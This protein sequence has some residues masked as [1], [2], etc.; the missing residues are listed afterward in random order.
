MPRPFSCW[1]ILSLCLLAHAGLATAQQPPSEAPPKLE[2]IEPGSD[3]PAT[4]VPD[5]GRTK[6]IEKKQGGQVTEV[7]VQSGKSRYTMKP[8]PPGTARPGDT[9]STSLRGPQWE[10][11]EFDLGKKKK[12]AA[13]TPTAADAPPP[14]A[15]A[16]AKS[17]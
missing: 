1:K 16:P 7:Q 2:R 17:K 5:R 6:I 8:R 3:T 12:G 10:V 11:L 14:P 13:G 9:E 15:P 4:T